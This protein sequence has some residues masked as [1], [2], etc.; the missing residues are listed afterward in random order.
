MDIK[1]TITDQ[2]TENLDAEITALTESFIEQHYL[3][4]DEAENL[5]MIV[6]KSMVLGE[7]YERKKWQ[8]KATPEG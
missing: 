7:L 4:N 2:D 5:E 1:N 8:D 6:A 3:D